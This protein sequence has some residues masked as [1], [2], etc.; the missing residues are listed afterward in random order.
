MN[1]SEP[2]V[3]TTQPQISTNVQPA[4]GPPKLRANRRRR[5]TALAIGLATLLALVTVLLAWTP[6]QHPGGPVTSVPSRIRVPMPLQPNLVDAPN[7]PAS[8]IVSGPGGFGTS[9]SSF[10]D[11]AIVVGRD[12]LY[13]YVRDVNSVDAG[14]N[15]LLSVDGRYVAGAADLEGVDFRESASDWESTAGVMDLTT[16]KV[17]T[18][19]DGAPVAWSPDGRLLVHASSGLKLL[20][21]RSGATVSLGVSGASAAFSP[22]GHQLVLQLGRELNVLNVDTGVVRTLASLGAAQ[23]LAGPGAWRT[24][25][26]LAIW[27]GNDCLPACPASYHDFRLSFVDVGTGAVTDGSFDMVRA[28]SARLLGWQTDGDGV[29]VLSMTSQDPGGPHVGAP[30]VLSLHPGGGRA[31]LVT[32]TDH[33]NRIDVA[34]NLLDRFGGHPRSTWV[35][36]LDLLRVQLRQAMP[37]LAGLAVLIAVAV[38]FRR[39]RARVWR[40]PPRRL[41]SAS[42]ATDT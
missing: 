41:R 24:D 8:V 38:A 9:D 10:D 31:T 19:L 6:D 39:I 11:R 42:R 17:R 4:W 35:M 3:A 28:V 16:G 13:R 23:T 2:A 40:W 5:L 29:V 25:G 12:G 37:W 34:R 21:I 18:Y 14:E 20:N 30:Q 26:R 27:T 33:A 32:V 15:L 36:F 1:T 22:D 7:G